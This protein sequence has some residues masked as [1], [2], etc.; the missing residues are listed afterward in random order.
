M[1]HY[2]EDLTGKVPHISPLL[3]ELM[4]V[5]VLEQQLVGGKVQWWKM[6]KGR[7][8]SSSDSS[9]WLV[10]TVMFEGKDEARTR[11]QKCNGLC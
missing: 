11:M 10:Q 1:V 4:E 2:I 6:E 9:L 5:D 8:P 7:C 3:T